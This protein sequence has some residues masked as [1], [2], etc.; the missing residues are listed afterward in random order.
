MGSW[1]NVAV[2]SNWFQLKM[3]EPPLGESAQYDWLKQKA[4]WP[5]CNDVGEPGKEE[6]LKSK[7]SKKRRA[8]EGASGGRV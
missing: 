5:S 4:G 2:G 3:Q 1:I 6:A 7:T 8:K